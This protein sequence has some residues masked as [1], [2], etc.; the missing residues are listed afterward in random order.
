MSK[1]IPDGFG[2]VTPHLS[3]S[4]ASE[5]LAF[6][7]RAF[8]A[9]L[10]YKMD[11]PDGKAIIH[12][13]VQIGSSIIFLSD[14]LQPGESTSTNLFLYVDDVDAA[15]AK[16]VAAG[17]HPAVPV[18]DMF[19]G[20]RWGMV[21]DPFGNRWQIATHKEDVAPEEMQRRSAEAFASAPAE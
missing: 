2:T 17:A 13:G 18:A 1:K 6:L 20:D 10:L 7:E 9:V 14:A 16:A 8:G 11:T 3:V 19:W 12:S 15:Y 5:V 4:K 21:V